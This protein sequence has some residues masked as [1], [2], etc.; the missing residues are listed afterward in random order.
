VSAIEC[1][2]DQ[3]WAEAVHRYR[4]GQPWHIDEETLQKIAKAEQD[5]R[6]KPSPW[7]ALIEDYIT[8]KSEVA[9]ASILEDCLDVSK[10]HQGQKDMNEVVRC[11]QHLGWRSRQ[12]RRPDGKRERI[13]EKRYRTRCAPTPQTRVPLASVS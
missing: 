5:K 2:R 6:F 8:G 7:L 10:A 11:L 3:L 4:E 12:V 1:D 13:Y 9:V